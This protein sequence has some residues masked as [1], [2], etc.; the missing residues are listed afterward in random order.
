VKGDEVRQIRK[1]LG[2]TQVQ[3]AALVGVHAI[4]VSRWENDALAIREP[5]AKLLRLLGQ[6]PQ[7]RRMTRK[8]R[9]RGGGR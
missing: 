3:F 4:T 5:T 9:T 8:R 1:R 7:G 6:R 2:L